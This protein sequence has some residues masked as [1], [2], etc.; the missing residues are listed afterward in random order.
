LQEGLGAFFGN[1][2][3]VVHFANATRI[4]CANFSYIGEAGKPWNAMVSSKSTLMSVG[5]TS[6]V[7]SMS[8][9]ATSS[10]RV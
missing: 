5:P 6:A 9:V 4:G 2:S 7:T 3:F 8:N 1:R 10:C